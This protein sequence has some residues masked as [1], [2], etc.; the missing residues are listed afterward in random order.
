MKNSTILRNY[1]L[2][3]D[4]G[5]TEEEIIQ[6][7]K[8]K[9]VDLQGMR[10]TGTLIPPSEMKEF[11]PTVDVPFVGELS[12]EDWENR[13]KAQDKFADYLVDVF[14][15]YGQGISFN[16]ADELEAWLRSNTGGDTFEKEL[17]T[18]QGK[19]KKFR[20]SP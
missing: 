13:E 9:G 20:E 12:K 3:K 10:E 8:D 1:N 2:L 19:I 15:E 14:R 5:H 7:F 17:K 11:F 6:I 4:S 18:V 16:S